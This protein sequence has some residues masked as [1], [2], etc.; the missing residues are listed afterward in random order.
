MNLISECSPQELAVSAR[1]VT[2]RFRECISV[3]LTAGRAR[4][5]QAISKTFGHTQL[6][7]LEGNLVPNEKNPRVG[8]R[9]PDFTLR[10]TTGELVSLSDFRGRAEVVLFFYPK[11]DLPA[12]SV[13]ACSFRDS[14]ETFRDAGAEVIGVS[15]DS[16]ESHRRFAERLRLP[17]RLLSDAGGSVRSRYGVSRTFGLIPGRVT[18]LIDQQGIVRHVFSSQFQ[19]FKHVSAM[20]GVLRKLREQTELRAAP[21]GIA[22][23]LHPQ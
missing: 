13:E 8:D 7:A 15:A 5:P 6:R 21:R 14:Y 9:A 18:F 2:A 16:P 20:L 11:D 23:P 1:N 17:F 19:P 22:E 12:C 3:L 10:A 4:V